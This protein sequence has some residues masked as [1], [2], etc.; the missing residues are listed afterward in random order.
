MAASS[1]EDLVTK[2]KKPLIDNQLSQSSWTFTSVVAVTGEALG[3]EREH[4][5]S[6]D[7]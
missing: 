3:I 2:L 7:T 1:F 5:Y 6:E 4:L